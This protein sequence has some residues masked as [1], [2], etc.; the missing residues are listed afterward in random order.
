[1][2]GEGE[3]LVV[4]NHLH[5]LSTVISHRLISG[6]ENFVLSFLEKLGTNTLELELVNRLK[7]KEDGY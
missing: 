5:I 2:P 3:M 4:T 1:M 7:T 6:L